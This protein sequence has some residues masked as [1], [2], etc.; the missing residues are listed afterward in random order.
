MATFPDEF[1]TPPLHG[2]YDGT[3]VAND[4]PEKTGRVRA[5][6][7]GLVEQTAWA[8]PYGWPGAGNAKRGMFAPPALGSNVGVFFRGGDLDSPAYLCGP[9]GVPDGVP[10]TPTTPAAAAVADAPSIP[11]YETETFEV[12]IQDFGVGRERKLVM[13]NKV[14]GDRIE[15]DGQTNSMTLKATTSLSIEADGVIDLRGARV[16]IQGRIVLPFGNPI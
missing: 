5:R 9:P 2:I 6:V 7:P 15:L 12:F 1:D 13:R 4:D 8:P 14:N 11:A 3:V 10:D 16:Q